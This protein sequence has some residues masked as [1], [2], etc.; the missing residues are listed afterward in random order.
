MTTTRTFHP[1]DP[2]TAEEVLSTSA[3]VRAAD[4]FGSLSERMRFVTIDLREPPKDAVISWLDGRGGPPAREAEV[5]LLDRG[6][7]ATHEVIVS[8]E[9]DGSGVVSSWRRREDVQ[10]MAVVTE[11]MEA[12]DLV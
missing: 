3:A 11:L 10:P 6:D 9:A 12:E 7:G 8:L 2:L 4:E 1:L 5:V